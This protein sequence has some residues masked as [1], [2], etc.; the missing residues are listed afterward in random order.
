ML[1]IIYPKLDVAC[2][3][4]GITKCANVN[5]HDSLSRASFGFFNPR[6]RSNLNSLK[7]FLH[8][9]MCCPDR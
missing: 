7:F 4:I 5:L 6:L 8:T 9:G 1:K 2:C 3:K